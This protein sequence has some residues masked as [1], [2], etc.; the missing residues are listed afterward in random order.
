MLMMLEV[1]DNL[2]KVYKSIRSL[3]SLWASTCQRRR[4]AVK[5]P[6]DWAAVRDAVAGHDVKGALFDIPPDRASGQLLRLKEFKLEATSPYVYDRFIGAWGMFPYHDQ[7][8]L[9]FAKHIYAYFFL[10]MHPDYTSTPSSFYGAGGGRIHMRPRARKDSGAQ[11][12]P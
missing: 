4:V 10:E 12:E 7:V 2:L 3:S 5:G 1:V 6:N 11:P 8:P 9:Y